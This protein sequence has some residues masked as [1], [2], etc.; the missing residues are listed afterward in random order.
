M[1]TC[2]FIIAATCERCGAVGI[3]HAFYSKSKR[4]CSLACSKAAANG[5]EYIPP[6]PVN[7]PVS[8]IEG[9]SIVPSF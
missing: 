9:L 2:L 8:H 6:Q 7:I 3:K 1:M 5:E 4:F